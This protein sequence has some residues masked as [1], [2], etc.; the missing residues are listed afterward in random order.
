MREELL[1]IFVAILVVLASSF[2]IFNKDFQGISSH[3]EGPL[4][5]IIA[6]SETS[7]LTGMIISNFLVD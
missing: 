3:I 4:P 7:T 5:N 2:I 1:V 6:H